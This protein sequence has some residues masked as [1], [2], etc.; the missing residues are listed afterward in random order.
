MT[1]YASRRGAFPQ[2]SFLRWNRS[3]AFSMTKESKKIL[4]EIQH[5]SLEIELKRKMLY[6]RQ[7]FP[8]LKLL[9]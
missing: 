5:S 4:H 6:K 7:D 2:C 1:V 3:Y 8:V 9:S